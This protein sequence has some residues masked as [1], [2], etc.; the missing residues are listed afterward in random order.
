MRSRC[1]ALAV[2]A[3][4]ALGWPV[5]ARA[6]ECPIP[7]GT[8]AASEESEAEFE[9][10]T[11]CLVNEER[12]GRGLAQLRRARRLDRAA[13]RHARD[14]VARHYFSHFSP[15]GN[16]LLDRVRASR[17]LRGWPSYTLG[18][19]LAWGTGSL[20]SPPS[21]MRAWLDSPGHLHVIAEPHFRDFGVAVVAGVP[22]GDPAGGT[23]AV[24]FGRRERP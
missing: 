11:E 14:M 4:V 21:I 18:E 22:S 23:Y 2:S 12:A 13:E 1:V 8:P 9:R 24:V 10:A 17:Y 6:D 5:P 7:A 15:E 3:L 19:V 20:G 16:G